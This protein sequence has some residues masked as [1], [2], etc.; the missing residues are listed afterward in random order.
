MYTSCRDGSLAEKS[1]EMNIEDLKGT[2]LTEW[3]VWDRMNYFHQNVSEHN[4]IS[5]ISLFFLKIIYIYESKKSHQE[6]VDN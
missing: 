1:M 2:T 4:I 5:I 6:I 3:D